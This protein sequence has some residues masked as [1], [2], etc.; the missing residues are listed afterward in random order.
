[1]GILGCFKKKAKEEIKPKKSGGHG[2]HW[3]TVLE[4]DNEIQ[5]SVIGSIEKPEF[6]ESLKQKDNKIKAFF[7]QGEMLK[8]CT[9]TVNDQLW[10]AYPFVADGIPHEITIDGIEEW[11]NEQEAQIRCS[12]GDASFAFFDTMYFKNRGIY[13]KGKKYNFLLSALAYSLTK[14][15]PKTLTDRDGRELSTKGMAAFF[16]FGKG[17]ID[18]F[19]FQVPVKEVTELKFGNRTVYRIKVSLFRKGPL[20]RLNGEDD[21]D[22]F[23][24]VLANTTKGY[25]PAVGDDIT[26]IMW[27]QGHVR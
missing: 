15:E 6:V 25:V 4:S 16:P 11:I 3:L 2:D 26:G 21:I 20:Y 9:I 10:T 27:L 5:S 8:T 18:D 14:T 1:M 12:L 22:L 19:I 13:E 7:S 24:F 17:D 23:I